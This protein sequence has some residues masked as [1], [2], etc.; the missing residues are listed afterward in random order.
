VQGGTLIQFEGQPKLLELSQVPADHELEF[1]SLKKFTAFNTNNL[2]VNLKVMK[3]LVATDAIHQPVIVTER[4]WHGNHVL[5][6]E[7]A[8]GAA[9]EVSQPYSQRAAQRVTE[10]AVHC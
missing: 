9:I 6:L 4:L 7:T 1:L 10:L 8:A 5:Q 2:W 3:S